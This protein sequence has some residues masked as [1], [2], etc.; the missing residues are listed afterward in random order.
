[1]KLAYIAGPYRAKEWIDVKQN[2]LN[3]ERVAIVALNDGYMPVCP[4]LV[5]GGFEHHCPEVSDRFW[6]DGT[7]L[8]LSKCDV[9][10]ICK[11]WKESEGSRLEYGWAINNNMPI[12][13]MDK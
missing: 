1:M 12:I 3:A 11:G 9:I 7:L 4:H 13:Y 2:I 8:L 6:L 10:Y 5:T